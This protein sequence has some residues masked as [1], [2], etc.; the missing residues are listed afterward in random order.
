MSNGLNYSQ[1]QFER[2]LRD[3]GL[4]LAPDGRTVIKQMLTLQDRADRET[5][6][7]YG[8]GLDRKRAEV[9]RRDLLR[10]AF[11]PLGKAG[12][13]QR[14]GR[15]TIVEDGFKFPSEKEAARYREL[16]RLRDLG[17]VRNI[18]PH[19]WWD[20]VVN[21]VYIRRVFADFQYELRCNSPISYRWDKIV[22][23]VKA[24]RRDKV[25][26]KLKFSTDTSLSKH[27]R[28][29]VLACFGVEIRVIK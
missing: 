28:R 10:Q 17:M 13:M 18:E 26:G 19:P 6:A 23:D 7:K 15:R 20:I 2:K 22:E 24:E 4:E 12:A 9:V 25:T 16:R 29:L 5:E 8:E 14:A 3:M 1:E 11:D 21:N 27:G